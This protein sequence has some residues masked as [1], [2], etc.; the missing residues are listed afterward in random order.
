M[1]EKLRVVAPYCSLTG[2]GAVIALSILAIFVEDHSQEWW[3]ATGEPGVSI[4]NVSGREPLVIGENGTASGDRMLTYFDDTRGPALVWLLVVV[5][6]TGATVA[7]LRSWHRRPHVAA[8]LLAA[9]A[10]AATLLG[11]LHHELTDGVLLAASFLLIPSA[12]LALTDSLRT[13]AIDSN[14]R[15]A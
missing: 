11:V 1:R 6:M 15:K 9:A 14:W 12:L 8:G 13:A 5:A 10:G 7:G 2:L 3:I 4:L